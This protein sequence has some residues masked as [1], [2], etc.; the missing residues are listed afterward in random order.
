MSDIVTI[1]P[2]P[3]VSFLELDDVSFQRWRH[4]PTTQAF[5]AFLDDQ[6]ENW[7]TGAAA[8]VEDGLL[9]PTSSNEHLNPHVIRGKVL[10]FRALPRI[11]LGELQDFYREATAE[12]ET[13]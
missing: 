5:L 10:A 6:A 1:G 4:N 13:T 11:T 12:E 8:L 2:P 3:A 9:D 7:L